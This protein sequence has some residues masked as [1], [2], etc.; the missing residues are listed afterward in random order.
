MGQQLRVHR[1]IYGSR[2]KDDAAGNHEKTKGIEV[3][4]L[5][6]MTFPLSLQLEV[7]SHCGSKME[8]G[9]FPGFFDLGGG[10]KGGPY[11]SSFSKFS[12]AERQK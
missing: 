8:I 2:G 5:S 6:R 11:F 9:I 10:N 7:F 12:H 3:L 4:L 1:R